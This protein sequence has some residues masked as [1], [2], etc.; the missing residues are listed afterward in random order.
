VIERLEFCTPLVYS[1]AGLTAESVRS[2]ALRDRIK[3]GDVDLFAQIAEH[4]ERLVQ[5]G[6]F[7]GFFGD[8]VTLV[9]VPGHAPLARG[10][11]LNTSRIAEALVGRGLAAS[12]SELLTRSVLVPKSAWALPADRPKALRHFDTLSV[13]TPLARPQRVLLVDDV[14]TRGATFIGAASRLRQSFPDLQISA[15]ALLR[16]VTDGEI[17]QIRDPCS[18]TIE[19]DERGECW[20]RP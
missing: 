15:F 3:G 9:P 2:R 16:V 19:L 10:A 1:T 4:V 12:M 13:S 17:Q 8:D 20:R 11:R 6:H 18:G 5:A 7:P 14:L